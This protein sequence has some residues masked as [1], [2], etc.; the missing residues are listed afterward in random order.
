MNKS[1]SNTDILNL[2]HGQTNVI[3]Y[4]DLANYNS[5]HDVLDPYGSAV[6]LYP[7]E[8]LDNGHWT[9]LLYSVNKKGQRVVEFFDP[10]GF[11]PDTEFRK[12]KIKLPRFLARLLMTSEMPLEYNNHR[13][14][15]VAN[16]IATCGRHC[17]NR[18]RNADMDI[19]TYKRL[20]GSRDG[21]SADELVTYITDH[22]W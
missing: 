3:K 9:C 12:T 1:L 20:F 5:V 22:N 10:Y 16:N 17:V 4:A 11:S 21:I 2:L 15:K 19:D 6:I 7:A 8:T 14:Q 13:I 18:I